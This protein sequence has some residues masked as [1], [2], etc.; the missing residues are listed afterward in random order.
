MICWRA[1][2][3][4]PSRSDKPD[5]CARLTEEESQ[6][7]LDILCLA[8]AEEMP[9]AGQFIAALKDALDPHDPLKKTG[10]PT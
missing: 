5:V 6:L 7:L 8:A 10:D 2:S 1:P 9:H 3:A 4:W